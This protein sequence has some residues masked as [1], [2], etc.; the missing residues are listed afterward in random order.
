MKNLKVNFL[1]FV[2]IV[3]SVFSVNTSL[4]GNKVPAYYKSAML[5]KEMSVLIAE[6]KANLSDAKFDVIGEYSPGNDK[7]LYVLVVSRKDLQDI[8]LQKSDRG[9]LAG[10]FK[11]GFY[12]TDKGVEISVLNPMYIFNAY[13]QKN[14]SANMDKLKG[15]SNEF[16]NVVKKT[17]VNLTAFGGEIEA[18]DLWDY[19]YMLGMPYFTDPV[20][21]AEY[22]SFDN[23]V[24]KIKKNL[25]NKVGSTTGVFEIIR[26][27][28]GVA[29]FGIGLL[30][31]E[32][33]ESQFLP[34]IG[35]NHL[36]AMPY[37]I[38][39]QGGKVTMLH[40]RYRIALHWPELTMGTFTKIMSTPGDIEET[41]LKVVK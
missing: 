13:L 36:A 38:I 10:I 19:H 29:V 28:K 11:V 16:L 17:G 27:D 8:T 22:S 31:K 37:E 41:L 9:L 2:L 30:D 21:L 7:N 1:F 32:T 5:N 23:E 14:I 6:V 35:E 26:K 4:A 33:G 20:E 40:G 12:K 18:E 3:L 25:S 15:I 34:I 24:D 39:L